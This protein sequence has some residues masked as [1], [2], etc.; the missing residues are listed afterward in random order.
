MAKLE[1]LKISHFRGIET[2]E[3]RFGS[4]ITCIIGR[5]DSGK[6]TI[7]DAIAYLFAQSWS[8]HINDSDFHKCDTS[9]PIIIEG[10][11]SGV[12]E[13]LIK[14]FGKHIRG[15]D[16]NG[17]LIDDM[18]SEAA[19]NAESVLTIRLTIN[20]DLEPSWEVVSN[21]GVDS[22]VIKATDRGKLNVFAISDYTDRHFSMNKGNPL[23]SLY[24]QLS[25]EE[26]QDNENVVLDVVRDA[27]NA[28]DDAV[29][30]K[31]KDTIDKIK[32]VAKTLGV[33][34]SELKAM[35]DHKDI[36]I[37]ENKVS[38]HEDGVPFRLK[39]KG[40]KR[41]LSLAIQ[42]SLTEPSGVILIDEIEQ[43]L[44]PYRVRHLVSTLSG[45]KDRQVIITTHSSNVIVELPC[46]ALYV[47]RENAHSLNHVEGEVQ[48]A[49]RQNPEAFFAKKVLICEGATEIGLGRSIDKYRISCGK[50]SM[51]CLGVCLAD[52]RGKEM[53]NYV[54]GFNNLGYKTALFCDSD[55]DTVKTKKQQ[56]REAGVEVVDC[57]DG[58][59]IE[60]QIFN[61]LSWNGVKD[62]V[63]L[64]YTILVKG[65]NKSEDDA[66][67]KAFSQVFSKLGKPNE[68]YKEDWLD[69][70]N[71]DLRK[72][73][74]LAAK[75]K[76]K[77]W[78]KNI[79]K[80]EALGG[81]VLSHWS[82][83][84]KETILYQEFEKLSNWI[85]A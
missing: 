11:V 29:K 26:A 45:Y 37:S 23:Y 65:E 18:E 12:P 22:T 42:L 27:K 70:E 19:V 17:E 66:K 54:M 69:V 44:E 53:E 5:G 83:L 72:G 60:Q 15:L 50:E 14:K 20:K 74:G 80:A 2:F 57:A 33:T 81:V 75:S 47:M 52:G 28:F 67:T 40:S 9:M 31:F 68:P 21:N 3:Q 79:T 1:I 32:G 77:S 35:L 39:G 13:D 38:I 58:F 48:G 41:L 71:S 73:L 43:G 56:F 62:A 30:D 84:D 78:Y 82:E 8:I 6:S 49:V 64:Y 10:V 51:A 4:G 61:D 46:D 36:A 16:A 34:L 7:L 25:G 63:S 85:D 55:D 76:D 59:S 24:K